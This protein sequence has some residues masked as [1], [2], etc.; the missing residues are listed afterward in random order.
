MPPPAPGFGAVR[1]NEDDDALARA[2]AAVHA[3]PTGLGVRS[4]QSV[5]LALVIMA[6]VYVA[7]VRALG[8]KDGPR[9]GIVLGMALGAAS[10]WGFWRLTD[11]IPH[12][13]RVDRVLSER[14][15]CVVCGYTLRGVPAQPDG[16][17]VCPECGS[18]WRL[19]PV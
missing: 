10:G 18:A 17:T 11:R 4:M 1:M 16:C 9:G 2:R 12:A 13:S 5:F 6:M 19:P 3:V 15:L 14:R 8:P 7:S